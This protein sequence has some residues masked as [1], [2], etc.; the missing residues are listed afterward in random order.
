MG[1]DAGKQA[2][3]VSTALVWRVEVNPQM[4]AAFWQLH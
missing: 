1:L 4:Q 3:I 2:V